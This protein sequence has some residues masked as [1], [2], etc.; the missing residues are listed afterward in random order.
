MN[1]S[2]SRAM[3]RDVLRDDARRTADTAVVEEDDLSILREAVDQR[4][5][6]VV[7]VP[8]EVLEHHQRRGGR[9]LVAEAAVDERHVSDL[10]REVLRRQL[11]VLRRGDTAR[12]GQGFRC[13]HGFLPVSVSLSGI[14]TTAS[15]RH[16]VGVV[17]TPFASSRWTL[18]EA[19]RDG[20]AAL[21]R[22]ASGAARDSC[23]SPVSSHWTDSIR[24]LG[25]S[26]TPNP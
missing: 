12:L 17:P 18:G 5:V 20:R 19:G 16:L 24:S 13:T 3:R 8:P 10:E 26:W 2:A 11:T 1:A 9:L 6:P 14:G 23:S 7:E 15:K 22:E 21:G 25:H 4:R